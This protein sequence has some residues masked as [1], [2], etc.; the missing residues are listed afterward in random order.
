MAKGIVRK[1]KDFKVVGRPFGRILEVFTPKDNPNINFAIAELKTDEK[2]YHKK[3]VEVYYVIKGHGTI[4][5]DGKIH[6]IRPGCAVLIPPLV[7]HRAKASKGSKLIIAVP[8]SPPFDPSDVF[9]D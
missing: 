7:R 4:E 8:S 2:H 6:K 9:Y 1:P 5:L 3:A